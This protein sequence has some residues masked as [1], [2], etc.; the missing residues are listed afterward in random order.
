[1]TEVNKRG[2][3]YIGD[4]ALT[5]T[6]TFEYLSGGRTFVPDGGQ[7]KDGIYIPVSDSDWRFEPDPEPVVFPTKRDAII[8]FPFSVT[9]IRHF[10]VEDLWISTGGGTGYTYRPEEL[11]TKFGQKFEVIFE[12]VEGR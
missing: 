6:V 10:A 5:G 1:M 2:K 12:G 7:P 11:I 4:Q 8:K 9:F 3:V